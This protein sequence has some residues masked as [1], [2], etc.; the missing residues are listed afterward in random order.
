MAEIDE[1]FNLKDWEWIAVH[2]P[3]SEREAMAKVAW[4]ICCKCTP[5][6]IYRHNNLDPKIVIP[7][8]GIVL[9]DEND[10]LNFKKFAKE[11]KVDSYRTI[12]EKSERK[13]ENYNRIKQGFINPAINS[14]NPTK[15]WL[16]LFETL[17]VHLQF[18]LLYRLIKYRIP[19]RN[20]WR[21]IFRNVKDTFLVILYYFLAVS[22][23]IILLWIAV[24]TVI[25]YIRNINSYI[26][27][28]YFKWCIRFILS[29]FFLIFIFLLIQ[30]LFPSLFK[31]IVSIL[32]S[33][34][35][36]FYIM[37][38]IAI[39]VILYLLEDDSLS[40]FFAPVHLIL[41]LI[42]L[43]IVLGTTTI[44]LLFEN[45]KNNLLSFLLLNGS[46]LLFS[47]LLLLSYFSWEK[48]LL[49]WAIMPIICSILL[50]YGQNIRYRTTNPLKDVLKPDGSVNLIGL[51]TKNNSQREK[52]INIT[53]TG[54]SVREKQAK[55]D[56]LVPAIPVSI[57]A[58]FSNSGKTTL[59]NQ[60]V[61]TAGLILE[62]EKNVHQ[63][64]LMI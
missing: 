25:D 49:I 59:V 37:G 8:C 7:L 56:K 46:L 24:I 62:F 32:N 9:L 19:T 40:S 50:V 61:E 60:I 33:L 1:E 52:K 44:F 34:R 36:I 13:Q 27:I 20:D 23:I 30:E 54:Y 17:D 12:L 63:I 14:I 57:V 58:G 55:L 18:A 42:S 22:L 6:E 26:F 2:F 10:I 48:T 64:F 43:V 16:S 5:E 45:E 21:N 31:V 41:I 47:L 4:L 53:I 28:F 15:K 11:K 38:F 35:F 51:A 29:F 39:K 3:P